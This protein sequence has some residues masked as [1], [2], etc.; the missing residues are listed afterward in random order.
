M[1]EKIKLLDELVGMSCFLGSPQMDCAILGEGNTSTKVDDKT[2]FIKASGTQLG[3]ITSEGFV[4]IFFDKALEILKYDRLTDNEMTKLF[5]AAKVDSNDPRRP[6][7]EVGF[8]AALLSFAG[9]NFVGHTH[10]TAVNAI[11]C[12]NKWREILGGRL[13]PD[14]IV[15]CGI[16]SV[17]IPYLE[18]GPPLAKAIRKGVEDFMVSNGILPKVVMLQNHGLIALGSTRKQVESTTIMAVKAARI[19]SG[20]LPLGGPN[21][22]TPEQVERIYTRPDEKYRERKLDGK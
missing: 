9:V 7:I 8:H 10:P 22:L 12:S 6:S 1:T 21:F 19:L 13:F 5:M 4:E 2:F 3:N 14:E 20:T 16:E 11:L 17:L 18:P 15:S